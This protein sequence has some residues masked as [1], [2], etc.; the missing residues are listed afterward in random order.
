MAPTVTCIAITAL[1]GITP[2][3][4]RPR[5]EKPLGQIKSVRLEQLDEPPNRLR[6]IDARDSINP[7]RV[8]GG[9][10][11]PIAAVP[12]AR[13]EREMGPTSLDR[14]NFLGAAVRYPNPT[15][16]RVAPAKGPKTPSFETLKI[17][18]SCGVLRK[19]LRGGRSTSQWMFVSFQLSRPH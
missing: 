12:T 11:L 13:R 5:N 3:I 19:A 2:T 7:D 8:C 10:L 17:S 4:D 9:R 6:V 14:S 15:R 16:P 18:R 1:G